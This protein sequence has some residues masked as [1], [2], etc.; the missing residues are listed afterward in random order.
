MSSALS[1]AF[2]VATLVAIGSAGAQTYPAKP[3]R[4]VVPF[5]P[6]GAVDIIGRIVALPLSERLKQQVVIDNRGGANAIIGTEIVS[7]ASPDGYTVL[8]VPAGHAIN[9]SAHKKLP[10]DTVRDFTPIGLIGHGAYLLVCN[11]AVPAKNVRELITWLKSQPGKVPFAASGVGNA[12]HLAAELFASM[13]ETPILPVF[14]KGGGPALNDLLGGQVQLFF[15]T[16]ASSVGHLRSGKIR[17]I[18]VSTLKRAA[19]LPD[20]PTVAESGLPGY[21]VDGWY[22]LLAPARTPQAI[23]E[24]LNRELSDALNDHDLRDRLLAA[25]VDARASTPQELGEIIARDIDKW[26]KLIRSSGMRLGE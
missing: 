16:V 26:A 14:Y 18:A 7:H 15:A 19:A 6:A 4:M 17:A 25:G 2:A 1:G 5:P 11:S 12:T 20:I 24:R 21:E 3:I 9:P 10:F 13:A 23:V 8:I 22:G